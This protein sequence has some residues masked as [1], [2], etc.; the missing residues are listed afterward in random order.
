VFVQVVGNNHNPI[1]EAG[2]GH[3][4]RRGG[5]ITGGAVN[6]GVADKVELGHGP[7]CSTFVEAAD[8]VIDNGFVDGTNILTTCHSDG[9][10]RCLVNQK[11]A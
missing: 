8:F 11:A 6:E 3:V 7:V 10:V 5:V 2:V 1:D 4:E 9:F